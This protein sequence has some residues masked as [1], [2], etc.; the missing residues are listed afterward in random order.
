[1]CCRGSAPSLVVGSSFGQATA[2]RWPCPQAGIGQIGWPGGQAATSRARSWPMAVAYEAAPC[3]PLDPRLWWPGP[4]GQGQWPSVI[5]RLASAASRLAA[6]SAA[7][8]LALSCSC[9]CIAVAPSWP[10]C[11]RSTWHPC[12]GGRLATSACCWAARA[13]IRVLLGTANRVDALLLGLVEVG[14]MEF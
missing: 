10:G 8:A 11:A 9:Q 4:G 7:L 3:A 12:D 1:M 2:N 13:M 5:V 14:C 6:R